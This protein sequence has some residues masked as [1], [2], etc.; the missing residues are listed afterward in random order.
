MLVAGPIAAQICA[1]PK[2]AD[3]DL[4]ALE[5]AL[6][7]GV[8]RWAG[9]G[10]DGASPK[11]QVERSGLDVCRITQLEVIGPRDSAQALEAW[12]PELAPEL[13]RIAEG[14]EMALGLGLALAGDVPVWVLRLV[15][16]CTGD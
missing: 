16:V 2:T 11:V 7:T 1:I 10:P 5:Q 6:G 12:L 13:A 3:A 8:N 15:Q 9:S 14:T 4:E